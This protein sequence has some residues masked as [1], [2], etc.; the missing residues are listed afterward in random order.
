MDPNLIQPVV[1]LCIMAT[2]TSGVMMINH[3]TAPASE[4]TYLSERHLFAELGASFPPIFVA[5]KSI[6]WIGEDKVA[7]REL[8]QHP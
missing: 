1:N 3:C 8:V 6:I 5:H 4:S 2:G 7:A